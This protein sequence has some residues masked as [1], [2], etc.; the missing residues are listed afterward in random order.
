[1]KLSGLIIETSTVHLTKC[2]RPL[3]IVKVVFLCDNVNF[4]LSQE[5]ANN[6]KGWQGDGCR[7]RGWGSA[8]KKKR[9]IERGRRVL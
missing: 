9:C 8:E 4:P 6:M 1:M 5:I 3:S 2:A 7:G